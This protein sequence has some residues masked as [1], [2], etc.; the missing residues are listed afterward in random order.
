MGIK[1]ERRFADP[2]AGELGSARTDAPLL[3]TSK[4]APLEVGDVTDADSRGTQTLRGIHS[5]TVTKIPPRTSW[6]RSRPSDLTDHPASS[7]MNPFRVGAIGNSHRRVLVAE[8]DPEIRMML[9]EW[10]QGWGY[11][12]VIARGGIEAWDILQQERPPELVIMDRTMPE[13][14]GV[15][16]S[17][18]LRRDQ[19]DYY[20]YILLI[21]D[22]CSKNDIDHALESGADDYLVKPF[23]KDEM[24]ARL[25]AAN[26]IL[27]LQDNLIQARESLL[28]QA[29]KDGLTGVWNR[30]AL[31]ELFQRELDR[32]SRVK[33]PTGLLIL[34]LD[35]FKS[36]NDTYGHLT[37]DLALKET[38]SR[39][40]RAVRSYDVVGRYG[41]EEFLIVFPDCNREQL[42]RIAENIRSAIAN[43]PMVLGTVEIPISISIGAISVGFEDRSARNM[44]A[45]AD[46][47]L[48]RAKNTGRNRTVYCER[49]SIEILR[50]KDTH[51]GFC[52]RCECGSAKKCAVQSHAAIE[53]N[54]RIEPGVMAPG[55][56]LVQIPIRAIPSIDAPAVFLP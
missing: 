54:Q 44:I 50:T 10:L 21:T 4:M 22:K 27:L 53:K 30:A 9:Q 33:T 49:P 31:L 39:L 16:L 12:V 17:R 23:G 29:T 56:G 15:E 13:I 5:Q 42:C 24:K 11:Q 41:G 55:A 6:T 38:A 45:V 47:A 46:V 28:D 14:E 8:S 40:K 26:R 19:R 51:Q 48:Y 3:F 7:P 36:V 34:D 52:A 1:R 35:H 43:K 20:H 18:R 37:G 32:A 25:A 2:H